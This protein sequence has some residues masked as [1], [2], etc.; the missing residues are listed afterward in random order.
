MPIIALFV[1]VNEVYLGQQNVAN[2]S[3]DSEKGTN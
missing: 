3:I 2:S 1:I